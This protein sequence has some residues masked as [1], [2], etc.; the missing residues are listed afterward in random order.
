MTSTR[1][2]LVL[3]A[4][5]GLIGYGLCAADRAHGEPMS[6]VGEQ[7]CELFIDEGMT[8]PIVK[9]AVAGVANALDIAPS[10]AALVVNAS[11]QRYCPQFWS[12]LRAIGD[13]ARA[14]ANRP[15]SVV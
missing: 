9:E 14:A 12:T 15:Q 8:T 4:F 2:L 13:E 11:V 7:V 6:P 1:V 5:G 3:V 10:Q